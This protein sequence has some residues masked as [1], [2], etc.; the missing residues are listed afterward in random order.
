MRNIFT[1]ILFLCGI[2]SI[3]ATPSRPSKFFEVQ[4][5]VLVPVGNGSPKAAS[6]L[7]SNSRIVGGENADPGSAP[8]MASLQWGTV[9][10]AHFCGGAIINPNWVL[11]AGHCIQSF[12]NYGIRTVVA[13]LNDLNEFS[14]AQQIRHVTLSNTWV[15]EDYDGSVGPHDIGLLVFQTPF[16]FNTLVS[17]IA[18]PQSEQI[19]TGIA[20]L[21]GWGSVS[22]SFFPDYPSVLQSG[23]MPII[24]LQTC[25]I[26]WDYDADTIH[27][28]HICAGSLDGGV[29]ACSLDSGGSLTQNGVAV[30]IFSWGWVPCGQPMR[31]AIFV[32]V[33][34]YTS[35]IED[36][37]DDY[38][39]Q[40]SIGGTDA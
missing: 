14:S 20:V 7:K 3:Q 37:I 26:S 28:S 13:G 6:N 1:I 12:P 9:R 18:L 34:A 11:T 4:N 31:P 8:W 33:S 27:D 19:P 24:P 22:Y 35:W 10:P 39:A 2:I 29:G 15:H 21:H 25:R 16:T 36:I 40:M 5:G 38:V 17:A 23:S 32:R 30:G